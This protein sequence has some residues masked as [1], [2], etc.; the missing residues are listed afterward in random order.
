V[1][2]FNSART[3]LLLSMQVV[4]GAG[5]E[6]KKKIYNMAKYLSSLLEVYKHMNCPLLATTRVRT[7]KM[8]SFKEN[9]LQSSEGD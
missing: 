7:T 5:V 2:A 8:P 4:V 1:S 9:E 3:L 6:E